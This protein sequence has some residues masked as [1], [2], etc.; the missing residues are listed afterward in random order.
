[1]NV[2]TSNDIRLPTGVPLKNWMAPSPVGF[3]FP[4]HRERCWDS[5]AQNSHV[6]NRDRRHLPNER[7]NDGHGKKTACRTDGGSH[8]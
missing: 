8:L 3:L 1:M 2:R 6:G 5:G 7:V 4:P